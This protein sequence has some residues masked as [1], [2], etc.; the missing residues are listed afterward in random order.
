MKTRGR[1]ADEQ[2]IVDE[3]P[4]SRLDGSNGAPCESLRRAPGEQRQRAADGD[5]E[6]AQNEQPARRD[7]WR[8]R[9]PN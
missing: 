1:R 9:A 4:V 3:H 7:R 6:D 5:D 2:Q 8:R